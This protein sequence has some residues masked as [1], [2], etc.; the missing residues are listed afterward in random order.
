MRCGAFVEPWAGA[1]AGAWVGPGGC[2]GCIGPGAGIVPGA[3]A[4]SWGPRVA[5]WGQKGRD[6][7][8]NNLGSGFIT[9]KGLVI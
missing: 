7:K 1:G 5:I 3:G 4:G 6:P 2:M 9:Y 8:V